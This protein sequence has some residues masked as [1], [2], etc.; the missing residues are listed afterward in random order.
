M[1]LLPPGGRR[2]HFFPKPLARVGKSYT[3]THCV[4]GPKRLLQRRLVG[5]DARGAPL[6]LIHRFFSLNFLLVGQAILESKLRQAWSLRLWGWGR[7][8]VRT[9]GLCPPPPQTRK[10][11]EDPATLTLAL[12][13]FWSCLYKPRR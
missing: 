13:D 8:A 1:S 9:L 6:A 2:S 12:A 4:C 10:Q 3:L 7:G 11:E 5:G